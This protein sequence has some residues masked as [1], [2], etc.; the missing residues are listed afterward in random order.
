[1]LPVVSQAVRTELTLEDYVAILRRRWFWMLAPIVLLA[2]LATAFGVRAEP[3]YTATASVLLADSAAQEALDPGSTNTGLLTRR[4]ENEINFAKS[5]A[6]ES[7][8][9]ERLGFL[10]DDE[11]LIG[12]IDSA[13][14]LEFT[15]TAASPDDAAIWPNAWAEAYVETKQIEAE[16]SITAAV[17]QLEERL[18][19]L[20]TERQEIREPLDSLRDSLT[21]ATTEERQAVLTAQVARL[22][23]D[24]GPSLDLVDTQIAQVVNSIGELQLSGEVARSGTARVL[25]VASP[26]EDESGAPLWRTILL[27][28]VAGSVLG[29][30]SALAAESFDKTLKTADDVIAASGLP[31]LGSIPRPPKDL[32]FNE[33]FLATSDHPDSTIADGYQRV[34]NALQFSLLGKTVKSILITSAN[35]SEGKTTT[36]AN[37]AFA[38]AVLY[39][40]V[41]L[42]DVDFRRPR[43]HKALDLPMEPG[44]SNHLTDGTPVEELASHVDDYR[45]LAMIP[46]GGIPPNPAEFVSMPEFGAA[47]EALEEVSDL[48][49]LDGPPVLPVADSLSLAR[50]A[51]AVILTVLA[52]STTKEHLA[53]ALESLRQ[54]GGNVLGVVLIGVKDDALYGAYGYYRDDV[55]K[56][57][58]WS[59]KASTPAIAV[60]PGGQSVRSLLEEEA[61]NRTVPG[62]T[63]AAPIVSAPIVP[64]PTVPA[65]TVPA[66]TVESP[67]VPEKK[68]AS[69]VIPVPVP[70][71]DLATKPVPE[72]MDGTAV[73]HSSSSNGSNSNAH[74]MP[75]SLETAPRPSPRPIPPKPEPP[76]SERFW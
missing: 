31:V 13:D 33:L 75:L 4:I 30:A 53:H 62:P 8:V 46:C 29:V 65:P 70:M 40:R 34:S 17:D 68:P 73:E 49:V 3:E 18:T 71:A 27:G 59:G 74:G 25:Q 41:A 28:L 36:S 10:P 12:G 51:D 15:G 57:R 1:M 63:A 69:K 23:D 52:G 26:P 47:L 61:A 67:V 58:R 55:G 42:V 20:Q 72:R 22:A 2:G 43:L 38:M 7:L 44:F 32:P 5:D 24:L 9:A 6:T 45:M 60:A 39:K 16:G 64:A 66:P 21:R 56:A 14:V 19:N 37:L 48:V 11:V 54:V 35:Q 76:K 50:H